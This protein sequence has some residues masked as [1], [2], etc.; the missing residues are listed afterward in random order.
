MP[1]LLGKRAAL[2][3][4]FALGSMLDEMFPL[5]M[6]EETNITKKN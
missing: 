3:R 4:G 5:T 2:N 6:K 1:D